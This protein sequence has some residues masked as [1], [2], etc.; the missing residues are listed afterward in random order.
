MIRPPRP[1]FLTSRGPRLRRVTVVAL[2]STPPATRIASRK[3]A[4]RFIKDLRSRHKIVL[5]VRGVVPWEPVVVKS[6]YQLVP[7]PTVPAVPPGERSGTIPVMA[8]ETQSD[9][10]IARSDLLLNQTAP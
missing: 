8:I 9:L 1:S 2:G 6:K 3:H 4:R 5:T 7:V 10:Y